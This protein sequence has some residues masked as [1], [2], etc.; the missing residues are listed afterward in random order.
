MAVVKFIK[1]TQV[2]MGTVFTGM[3][4][5]TILLPSEV[6][7]LSF[8]S[9]FL[10]K[11]GVTPA[12]KLVMQCFGSQASLCGLLILTSNFSRRTFKYFGLAMVPY[13]IFD[14]YFWHI[15]A[16][17]LFGALGDGIGNAIFGAC[18]YLGYRTSK[19][20]NCVESDA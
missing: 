19:E 9:S 17:T 8:S 7:K 12:L 3:G 4:L 20:E 18:C 11:E 15:G 14:Y 10:G 5:V 6:A 2:F 13:F 16:L 1:N